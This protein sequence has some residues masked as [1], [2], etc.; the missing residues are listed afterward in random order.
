MTLPVTYRSVSLS[1]GMDTTPFTIFC[2]GQIGQDLK[3]LKKQLLCQVTE[4]HR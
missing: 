3:V 2:H 1:V 4:V